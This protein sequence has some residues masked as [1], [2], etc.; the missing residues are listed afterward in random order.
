MRRFTLA[1]GALLIGFTGILLADEKDLKE[2]EGTYT[3]TAL[4]HGIKSLE[5]EKLQKMKV[6]FKGETLAFLI[7]EEEKKAKI[8]VDASQ[9]PHTIDISPSEGPEKGKTFLG[10]YKTTKGDLQI[11]F[12][13]KQ[14][15]R[16]KEFKSDGDVIL[17]TLKKEEKK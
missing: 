7:D 5:K 11:A 1:M 8:K 15:E 4:E 6:T 12:T 3:V 2:L 10:I 13:E 14:G 9:Q 16:P 17:L